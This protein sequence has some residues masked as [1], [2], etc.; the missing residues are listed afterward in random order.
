MRAPSII[1][2]SESK[3]AVG[4]DEP[5]HWGTST[6]ATSDNCLSFPSESTLLTAK[7]DDLRQVLPK[8]DKAGSPAA[9]PA[10]Q[11]ESR[12]TDGKPKPA[13]CHIPVDD[14]GFATNSS[15]AKLWNTFQP[16]P[17]PF[18]EPSRAHL[19]QPTGCHRMATY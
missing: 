5:C 2:P 12:A 16:A 19:S 3:V 17:A 9:G 7:V 1:A 15:A 6:T 13:K 11:S 18:A 10:S 8:D 4:E 14:Q